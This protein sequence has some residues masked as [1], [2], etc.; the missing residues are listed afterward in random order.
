M[1][2]PPGI[3]NEENICTARSMPSESAAGLERP[4]LML[5]PPM[6]LHVKSA[7]K[8][9]NENQYLVLFLCKK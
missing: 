9:F 7:S 3:R 8:G 5:E 2:L 4:S 1:L 6:H